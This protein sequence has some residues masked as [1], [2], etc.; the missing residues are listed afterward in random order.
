MKLYIFKGKV[1]LFP[2][3]SGW[4]YVKTPKKYVKEF[5]KK[6]AQLLPLLRCDRK[7]FYIQ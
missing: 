7:L 1:E 4:H 2:Q 5:E 6:M 3:K